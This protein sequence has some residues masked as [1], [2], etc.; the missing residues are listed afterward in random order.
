[1]GNGD[2]IGHDPLAWIKEDTDSNKPA[3]TASAVAADAKPVQ[4]E[5]SPPAAQQPIPEEVSGVQPP[6]QES[7]Q[8]TQEPAVSQ[9]TSSV[10]AA[11]PQVADDSGETHLHLGEQLVIGTAGKVKSEW[12]DTIN[13]GIQSPIVL[14]GKD[15][16][17]IDTAGL[18]LVIA[19]TRELSEDGVSWRWGDRS[20]V[21][22]SSAEQ[23]G[24]SGLIFS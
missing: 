1:M 8:M 20:E 21:L 5:E 2:M 12:M 15:V 9:T 23:L 11:Q 24:V 22:Q 4:Q 14:D 19:L 10:S 18:Q 3:D 13:S 17:N 6:K 7:A 16:N